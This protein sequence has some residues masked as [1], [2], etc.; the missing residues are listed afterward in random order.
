MLY[1]N[2][3]SFPRSKSPN[4]LKRTQEGTGCGIAGTQ[5]TK[6][7]KKATIVPSRVALRSKASV[8]HPS[9]HQHILHASVL[10]LKSN[11]E[12]LDDLE[13]GHQTLHRA[14]PTLANQQK[15]RHKTK[16]KR[17]KR[18]TQ[19]RRARTRSLL[20]ISCLD[21]QQCTRVAS[22]SDRVMSP[23]AAAQSS[24]TDEERARHERILVYFL[25]QL[26][27]FCLPQ[28][29]ALRVPSTTL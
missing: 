8:I 10:H 9:V 27:F 13:L 26:F 6:D 3:K 5:K 11:N 4:R 19:D 16:G 18:A 29:T 22:K 7:G 15:P 24:K 12:I 28:G 25:P 14:P 21:A 2:K 17:N 1:I 20:G 23:T